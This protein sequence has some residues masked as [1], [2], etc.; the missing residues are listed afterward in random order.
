M[1]VDWIVT[2]RNGNI[3]RIGYRD[4][5]FN[6]F[7]FYDIFWVL[8]LVRMIYCTKRLRSGKWMKYCSFQIRD[9]FK[10][11]SRQSLEKNWTN[12]YTWRNLS[13]L[14]DSQR[15][16]ENW[17]VYIVNRFFKKEKKL[18][19]TSERK[20]QHIETKKLKCYLSHVFHTLLIFENFFTSLFS[21]SH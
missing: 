11:G 17:K 20:E 1:L 6:I 21:A 15:H 2:T 12:R 9:C 7:R 16:R 10:R 3:S 18:E 8:P 19:N 14:R 4:I 13:K 5:L